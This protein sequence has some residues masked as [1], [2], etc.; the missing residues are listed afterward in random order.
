M[1]L[2]PDCVR[3]ILLCLEEETAPYTEIAYD[4]EDFQTR[5]A[6]LAAYNVDEVE[7]HISQCNQNGFFCDYEQSITGRWA[8]LDITPKAHEFLANIREDTVWAGVK[9]IAKKVG[10]GS[11]DCLMQIASNVV[12]E[13]I[14]AQFGIGIT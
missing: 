4:K 3:D 10:S 8:I 13:L 12:T 1:R 7:Y 14:K 2:N 11:L 5:H 6:R 9:S